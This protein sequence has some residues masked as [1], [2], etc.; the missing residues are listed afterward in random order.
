W[1][2]LMRGE[3]EAAER[4]ENPV[5]TRDGEERII[6]WE[7][8]VLK[9]E[10]GTI[11]GSLGS[12]RDV[13][14][15]RQ[16]E[17]ER[18]RLV[19]DLRERV[20]EL[21][22]LYSLSQLT[23]NSDLSVEEILEESV[24]LIPPAWQY[25]EV[26]CARI[27]LEDRKYETP[28]FRKS[29]WSQ[30]ADITVQGE[31]A[32]SVQVYYM[33][34]KP[35]R[36]EGP[37]LKEERALIES[38]AETLGRTIERKRTEKEL[39]YLDRVL[40]TIRKI[41][42]FLVWEEDRNDLLNGVCE[43][44]IENRA[45]Y[46]CWIVLLDE[47]GKVRDYASSGLNKDFEEVLEGINQGTLPSCIRAALQ[48]SG[49][50]VIEDPIITCDCPLCE[51]YSGRSGLAVRLA[52][53]GTIYG[54]LVASVPRER[55]KDGEINLFE[56]VA[57]DVAHALA[58]IRIKTNMERLN[59]KL[60]ESEERYRNFFKTL[61]GCA[62]ITSK[63]GRWMDMSDTAPEF[64][65]YSSQEELKEVKIPDLYV[66]PKDREEHL[67]KIEEKGFLQDY[68]VELQKKDGTVMYTQI[69]SV[70]LKDEEGRVI[71]YQGTI[72][73]ITEIKRK[74]EELRESRERFRRIFEN[75]GDALY[76]VSLEGEEYGK[77]LDVNQAAVEQTGWR[78]EELVGKDIHT[79]A[80]GHPLGMTH[81]KV[82]EQL[83]K[84]ETVPL[85]LKRRRKDGSTYWAEETVVPFKYKGC[86]ASLAVSRDITERKEAE[87]RLR[88]SEEKFRL[89]AE[90]SADVI[91]KLDIESDN[92][93]YVSPS[94]EKMFGY[95]PQEAKSLKTEEVLTPES[96][97]RQRRVFEK[98]LAR[99]KSSRVLELEA[100]HKEGHIFPVEVHSTLI[101]DEEGRPVSILGVVRDV[102]ERMEKER[103]LRQ[104]RK[105]FREIFNNANDAIYLHELTEEGLPGR[106]REVNEVATEMLGYSKEEFLEMSPRDIDAHPHAKKVPQ[107]MGELEEEGEVRFEMVHRAKDGRE[108]PVEIHSRL[109]TLGGKRRV[110]S[111]ARDISQRKQKEKNLEESLE[112]LAM[113]NEK[114][115]VVGK[116]TR[117]D[118]R[119]KLSTLSN[120]LYLVKTRVDDPGVKRYLE[121]AEEAIKESARIFDFAKAYE[122]LGTQEMKTVDVERVVDDVVHQ[123]FSELKEAGIEVDNRCQGLRVVADEMLP[124]LFYNLFQNTLEH[125]GEGVGEIRVFCREC[126]GGVELVYED[127]GVGIPEEEKEKVFREGY[128]EGTGYG[129]YL[130]KKMCEVY[131]WTIQE[132]GNPDEGARFVFTIPRKKVGD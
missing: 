13:T 15:R 132:T 49:V 101:T 64:F 86:E 76:V 47:D 30:K 97:Q 43:L 35:T 94:V 18:E 1:N 36:D 124:R 131:G 24:K 95:T 102:T 77:I 120:N 99:G 84:G 106:F 100:I 17:E 60:Q 69:T 79:F 7:N 53:G 81:K 12:G 66:N 121:E 125:G 107:I 85:A 62:F 89:L 10:G 11:I 9:D 71:G 73:D 130:I 119:N 50:K 51:E 14:E 40:R 38:F 19:H 54:V 37:F 25:P 91:Y 127:D 3:I 56:E 112:M 28:N 108:I 22:C 109:F 126:E 44:L 83:K 20:K 48:Q 118:V 122:E 34:D 129:L 61:K 27:A 68:P 116:L 55:T 67:Q 29:Q 92:Y 42:Q 4:Y 90:N 32:G 110:L 41:N 63:G 78:E 2:P 74:T 93:E 52:Q 16:M 70:P 21:Q 31:I 111:I 33:E 65:G 113:L 103:E 87:I 96:F 23:G 105:R 98:D 72:R 5:L 39:S 80:V 82:A 75:L 6:E 58:R 115:E 57:S 46:N 123:L 59:Q 128:G 117:H 8:T 104:E 26:T 114:L 45:Y 88:K